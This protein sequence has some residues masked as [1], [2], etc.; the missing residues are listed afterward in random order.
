MKFQG[1]QGSSD[2]QSIFE[3]AVNVAKLGLGTIDYLGDTLTLDH[4]AAELFD[5]NADQ[6]VSRDSLHSRIHPQDLPS[7]LDKVS[8]LITPGDPDVIDVTHRVVHRNGDVKWVNARKRVFFDGADKSKPTSGLVAIQDITETKEAEDR[9]KLLVAEATHRTKNLMTLIQ[10]IARLSARGADI[11]TFMAGFT[12]R[13]AALSTNQEILL[14]QA[15][16][17]MEVEHLVR[18]QLRPF[19]DGHGG[20]ISISGPPLNL[21]SQVGQA[22]GLALNELATNAVKYGALSNAEGDIALAWKMTD[23]K[24]GLFE[25]QWEEKGGPIVIAPLRQGFGTTVLK[26]MVASATDGDVA[27]SYD[28]T[29]VVWRVQASVKNVIA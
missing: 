1:N 6:P 28:P 4:R 20:R 14:A 29:G 9:I 17:S 21:K 2:N 3:L 26:S 25:M 24:A 11:D 18:E 10:S 12:E 16:K 7:V 23:P 15:E 27:L 5:L 13:L 19:I 22:I 8:Y